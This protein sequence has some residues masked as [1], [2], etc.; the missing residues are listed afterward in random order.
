MMRSAFAV[1][2]AGLLTA[3][4]SAQSPLADAAKKAEEQRSAKQADTT[5]AD[6]AKPPATKAYSNKD[7]TSTAPPAI[8][9]TP[10]DA[11]STPAPTPAPAVAAATSD[12]STRADDYR[13]TAKKDEAYWKGRM[14]DLQ[15]A[16]DTDRIH[17]TTM[18]SRV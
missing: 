5:K 9:E 18:E 1:G 17:L 4:V 6:P 14:R 7:L 13:K 16:L 2:V 15:A 10:S 8:R 3:S 12:E 11:A